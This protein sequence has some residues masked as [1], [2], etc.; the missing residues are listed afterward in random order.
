MTASAPVS[1][2]TENGHGKAKGHDKGHKDHGDRAGDAPVA[3]AATPLE[4]SVPP[5]T[6]PDQTEVPLVPA[7]PTQV[8]SSDRHGPDDRGNNRDGG[9]EHGDDGG[10]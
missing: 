9:D 10:D 2:G 4:T 1:G 8:G 6:E 3:L 5:G 7:A